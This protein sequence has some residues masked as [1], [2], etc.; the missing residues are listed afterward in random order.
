MKT[1]TPIPDAVPDSVV[2]IVDAGAAGVRVIA[3]ADSSTA[4]AFVP[5]SPKLLNPA[6]AGSFADNRNGALSS[7]R[8]RSAS[9]NAGFSFAANRLAGTIR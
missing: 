7:F 4:C 8:P 5:P 9:C 1:P 6:M 3:G 2:A